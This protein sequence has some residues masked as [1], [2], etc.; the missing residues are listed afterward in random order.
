M[1]YISLSSAG[2]LH[3]AIK[4]GDRN[5]KDLIKPSTVDKLDNKGLAPLHYAMDKK[6]A[7]AI[8]LLL[9]KG[10]DPDIKDSKIGERPLHLGA[11]NS[12]IKGVLPLVEAGADINAGTNKGVTPLHYAYW[13]KRYRFASEFLEN[14]ADPTQLTQSGA[15]S[16]H[17]LCRN[18]RPVATDPFQMTK[19]PRELVKA[20]DFLVQKGVNTKAADK[21]GNTALHF[22]ANAGYKGGAKKLIEH[23]ANVNAKTAKSGLT[24]L[25]TAVFSKDTAMI[26]LLLQNGAEVDAK[27]KK[28]QTAAEIA[29]E[30]GLDAIALAIMKHKRKHKAK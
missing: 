1:S 9:L 24:P 14:G 2:P 26:K 25:H 13:A 27:N 17:W 21:G 15:S 23:G 29:A 20:I 6:N 11:L 18:P 16:L 19:E 22:C 5:I 28:G 10:A 3:D 8:I 30:K 4:Q 7:S 12:F